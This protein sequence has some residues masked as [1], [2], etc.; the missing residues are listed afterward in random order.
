M[1]RTPLTG[2]RRRDETWRVADEQPTA[3]PRPETPVSSE[4]VDLTQIRA[5]RRLTP[6]ERDRVLVAT[7]RN[8][9]QA[10]QNVRRL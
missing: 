4:G 5:L 2:R 6:T 3:A 10:K 1:V 8:L 7:V 9:Q